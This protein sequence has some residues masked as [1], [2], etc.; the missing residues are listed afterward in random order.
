MVCGLEI[1]RTA[2]DEVA[3][4]IVEKKLEMQREIERLF[5]ELIYREIGDL[6]DFYG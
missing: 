4:A 6:L 1:G 3:A 2:G 5:G